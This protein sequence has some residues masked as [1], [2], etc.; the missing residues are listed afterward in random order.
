MKKSDLDALDNA[1]ARKLIRLG[2]KSV[3]SKLSTP[4]TPGVGD[5]DTRDEDA[6]ENVMEEPWDIIRGGESGA[7]VRFP[8]DGTDGQVMT[9][10]AD[11]SFAW[12]DSTGATGGRYRSP[13]YS[14]YGGGSFLFD[15]DGHVMYTLE[16]LE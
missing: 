7:P 11:G 1:L 4:T 15:S 3:P 16:D 6:F 8:A 10:Q 2:A 12:E 13:M 9:M 5:E 14:T